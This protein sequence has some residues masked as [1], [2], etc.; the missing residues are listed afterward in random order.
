MT[1]EAIAA[2]I[3]DH[4]FPTLHAG[5]TGTNVITLQIWLGMLGFYQGAIPGLL[6]AA[7]AQAVNAFRAQ[8]LAAGIAL[9]APTGAVLER[10]TWE[11]MDDLLQQR[12]PP[13]PTTLDRLPFPRRSSY[14]PEAKYHKALYEGLRAFAFPAKPAGA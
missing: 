2:I 11:A 7:T 4:K 1:P 9:N 8:Q 3:E 5:E 6:D 14:D 10:D 12:L 13:E